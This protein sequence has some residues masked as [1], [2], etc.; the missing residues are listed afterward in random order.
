[1]HDPENNGD[2]IDFRSLFKRHFSSDNPAFI[3]AILT[4]GILAVFYPRG[5]SFSYANWSTSAPFVY[6]LLATSIATFLLRPRNKFAR[7]AV[8]IALC[9]SID[10]PCHFMGFNGRSLA[11]CSGY[12]W[13][14]KF[15]Y[16]AF[17]YVGFGWDLEYFAFHFLMTGAFFAVCVQAFERVRLALVLSVW[18]VSFVV[19]FLALTLLAG[20]LRGSQFIS[21]L[22]GLVLLLPGL[23]FWKTLP[24]VLRFNERRRA[25]VEP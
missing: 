22:D 12:F 15:T 23:L 5:Y 11:Q 25:E 16:P 24:R 18:T 7:I 3:A 17:E 13:L 8:C 2:R 9:L 14:F 6:P 4:C 1:M 19:A 21:V 20:L 10:V